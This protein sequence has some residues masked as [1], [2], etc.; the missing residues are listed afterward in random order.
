MFATY[1]LAN[2]KT[3]SWCQDRGGWTTSQM[4]NRYRQASRMVSDLGLG[5]LAPLVDPRTCSRERGGKRG[6]RG[7]EARGR[8]GGK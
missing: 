1:S 6:G 3:E 7:E 4:V 2:G 5:D 8:D